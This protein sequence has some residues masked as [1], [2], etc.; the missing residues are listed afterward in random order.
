MQQNATH[1][2]T[3]MK[4]PSLLGP[5]PYFSARLYGDYDS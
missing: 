3:E 5:D 2:Q 4:N 1:F